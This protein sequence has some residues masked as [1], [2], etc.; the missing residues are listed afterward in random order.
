MQF[1]TG[2]IDKLEPA[3]QK[4][5]MSE[6]T[7]DGNMVDLHRENILSHYE[8]L[9]IDLEGERLKWLHTEVPKEL[10]WLMM[11]M[12][13]PFMRRTMGYMKHEDKSLAD[14]LTKVFNGVVC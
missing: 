10:Q 7:T 9:A 14:R 1:G 2:G 4:A 12:H 3:I 8:Q 13:V 6:A 5:L 11:D